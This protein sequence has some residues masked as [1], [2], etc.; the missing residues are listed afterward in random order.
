MSMSNNIEYSVLKKKKGLHNWGFMPSRTELD[1]EVA[2]NEEL[3]MDMDGFYPP[4]VVHQNDFGEY[5]AL[6]DYEE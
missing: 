1:K 5:Y 3:E 6:Q 2:F 4:E